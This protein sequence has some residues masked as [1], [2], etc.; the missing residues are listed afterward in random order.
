VRFAVEAHLEAYRTR[1]KSGIT[2]RMALM[3]ELRIAESTLSDYLT[4]AE[5]LPH[6]VQDVERLGFAPAGSVT[7]LAERVG[8]TEGPRWTVAASWWPRL[9]HEYR[10][11]TDSWARDMN[12]PTVLLAAEAFGAHYQHLLERP[13]NPAATHSPDGPHLA[14]ARQLLGEL[15]WLASGPFGVAHE[16]QR[17]ISL[18]APLSPEDVTRAIARNVVT[19]QV[20]R[21]LDRSLRK[22]PGNSNLTQVYADL[23]ARP[24]DKIYR[25]TNWIRALRQLKLQTTGGTGPSRKWIIDQLVFA[26]KGERAYNGARATDRRYAFWCL[27][28]LTSDGALWSEVL[29]HAAE[30]DEVAGLLAE[31]EGLRAYVGRTPPRRNAFGY[32]PPTHWSATYLRDGLDDLLHPDA[33]RANRWAGKPWWDWAASSRTRFKERAIALLRD[34]LF[35][36]DVIRQRSA[37][38]TF[39]AAGPEVTESVSRT[40]V[41]VLRVLDV[42]SAFP[43]F[44]RERSLAYLGMLGSSTALPAV[45]SALRVSA[46]ATVVQAI[47]TAGDLAHLHPRDS[48]GLQAWVWEKVV[49]KATDED[50]VLAG[51]VAS[52]ASRRDP[53][54]TLAGALTQPTEAVSSA[55]AW[56]EEVL[57][58]PRVARA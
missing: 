16:A 10:L 13:P 50:V 57:E 44:V 8:L 18:L 3:R 54:T 23:L 35:N 20:I 56:A 30:D 33:V 46:D 47:A 28:E 11:G 32:A 29:Q 34:A 24:P 12:P 58:D 49:E 22:A 41:E 51:I 7:R 4:K 40:L 9:R 5:Y 55:L 2:G 37:I 21:A 14:A 19:T 39:R 15:C 27:A 48:V 31:A 43:Q 25:R 17:L 45:E 52:V 6:T 1:E 36:P 42:T 53:K 26:L 38:D